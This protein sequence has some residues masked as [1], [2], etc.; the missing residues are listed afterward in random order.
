MRVAQVEQDARRIGA[1]RRG[2]A[3]DQR[4]DLR[5]DDPDDVDAAEHHALAVPLEDE[6]PG[7]EREPVAARVPRL[8]DES[9]HR[10]PERR[11]EREGC[12]A[13]AEVAHGRVSSV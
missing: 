10:E 5:V 3:V 13:G 7:L 1:G 12:G 4:L 11:L 9:D 6:R 2:D 8:A